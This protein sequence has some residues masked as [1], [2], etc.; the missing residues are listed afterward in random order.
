MGGLLAGGGG[1][2]GRECPADAPLIRPVGLVGD[3]GGL[4]T[5]DADEDALVQP[6]E[7]G[8]GGLDLGPGAKRVLAGVDVLPT[9][10]TREH[11]RAAVTDAERPDVE[12]VPSVGL[13]G[14]ADVAEYGSVR[15][16]GLPVGARARKQPAADLRTAEC[17]AGLGHDTPAAS[18]YLSE[19]HRWGERRLQPVDLGQARFGKMTAHG[20][21]PAAA[22]GH[23]WAAGSFGWGSSGVTETCIHSYR[24]SAR[25]RPSNSP[26][27]SA[28][29][30]PWAWSHRGQ[31]IASKAGPGVLGPRAWPRRPPQRPRAPRPRFP[32]SPR[33]R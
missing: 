11:L 19:L 20:W 2:G 28:R 6:V 3:A 22:G 13:Q 1:G 17:P 32:E 31:R 8:G 30:T 12:E 18:G 23:G 14:V 10:K 9:P 27:L 15:E 7:I 5:P 24:G 4:A 26:S 21:L 29:S 25:I 16:D 33:G